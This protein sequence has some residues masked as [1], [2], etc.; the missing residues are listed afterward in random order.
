MQRHS[1]HFHHHQHHH[2]HGEA[3]ETFKLLQ[4]KGQQMQDW[5]VLRS[6]HQHSCDGEGHGAEEQPHPAG[7]DATLLF[8]HLLYVSL[9][10]FYPARLV[11][12]HRRL[13]QEALTS[14]P[15]APALQ[16]WS[17]FRASGWSASGTDGRRRRRSRRR[18]KNQTEWIWGEEKRNSRHMW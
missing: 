7:G 14:A 18:K 9:Y 13:A 16:T 5:I 15:S 1:I 17:R 2:H 8:C 11:T 4:L 6:T 3:S 10:E 12:S